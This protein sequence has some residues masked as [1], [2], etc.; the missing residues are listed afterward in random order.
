MATVE[1]ERCSSGR[2]GGGCAPRGRARLWWGLLPSGPRLP[3]S[4]SSR[5]FSY[6][7]TGRDMT[8]AFFR[9]SGSVFT[10]VRQH[11]AGTS[12][13]SAVGL[14]RKGCARPHVQHGGRGWGAPF[15]F[16]SFQAAFRAAISVSRPSVEAL[17]GVTQQQGSVG[18]VD[19]W[20]WWSWRSFPTWAALGFCDKIVGKQR[21]FPFPASAAVSPVERDIVCQ[22]LTTCALS[23]ALTFSVMSSPDLTA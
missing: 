16:A 22:T 15:W 19:V 11:K 6:D 23:Q 3:R 21:V 18:P 14:L 4:H 1:R 17:R 9:C 20:P 12:A 13:G 8:T 5:R 10:K 7:A 2:G